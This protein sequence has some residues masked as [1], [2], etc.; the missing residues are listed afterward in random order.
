[1]GQQ[2]VD[3]EAFDLAAITI[4]G[5]DFDVGAGQMRSLQNRLT[6]AA[7]GSADDIPFQFETRSIAACHRDTLHLAEPEGV[8]GSGERRLFRAQAKP[9]TGIFAIGA[10]NDVAI[11]ALDRAAD[12]KA[13]IGG[14]GLERGLTGEG[15][16]LFIR[17]G[18]V[19]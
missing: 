4:G 17:H 9:V 16:E 18:L 15:D 5:E 8:L 2:I 6:T 14:V 10:G 13:A 1:M 12:R 7:A 11:D 19:F 3:V